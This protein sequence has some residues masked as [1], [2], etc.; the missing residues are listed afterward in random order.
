[1]LK[2][3][4]SLLFIFLF[5]TA[6]LC[7]A[8]NKVAT[9]QWRPA[10]HFTPIKTW[11]NDPNGLF[12]DQG[13]YH[14]YFQNNPFDNV[15]GHMSWGHAVSKDLVHWTHLPVAIP[16]INKKDTTISIFSG[17]AV[18]D[19][20]N[21]SGF[22]IHKKSPIVAIFTGDL[23]K[24]K[25]EA[26]Y[27][28]YSNDTGKTFKLYTDH[29]VIDLNRPDFRDPNVF[30]Y[31]PTKQWIMA[32]SLVHEHKIRFYSSSNLKQW[33]LLSDFG[34][35][36]YI[37][38]D[39]ECPS[40]MPL[41]VDGKASE[42]KWVLL[43]SCWG[44]K[45]PYMQY[46]I[47]DFDG[48]YFKNENPSGQVLT[49]DNGDCFY[50][51]I[52]WRL[53]KNKQILLGWLTPG[54]IDTHPWRGQMS[55][56]RDLSLRT[57]SDGIRLFQAPAS[58]IRNKLKKLSGGKNDFWKN[59]Y[60][61]NQILVPKNLETYHSNAYWIE[62]SFKI[63][64]ATK[65]GFNIMEDSVSGSKIIVGYD[66]GKGVLFVNSK[67]TQEKYKSSGNLFLS[68]PL[69]PIKG[70]IQLQILLDKSSLE[71]F[72]NDG[73]KVI[74]TITYPTKNEKGISLFSEGK[75]VIEKMHIWDLSKVKNR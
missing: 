30:W 53:K 63:S 75:T 23:P 64:G 17:S 19:K 16:E 62:A 25:K 60:V 22:A 36:G 14:L 4:K 72:G 20:N 35:A 5:C 39:W 65:L 45:G 38:H 51:A 3:L 31:K 40:L 28:A 66:V 44:E 27:I 48:Q 42:T 59:L 73:R 74:T 46:F 71:V 54:K 37:G 1:M 24:Q 8:Q 56:P 10:Y 34:P 9:P 29:P 58:I 7:Q 61:N 6:T 67:H 57:T 11:T 33:H 68:T 13:L 2:L 55:I 41:T 49:V 32:V 12:Y 18:M 70:K 50:A 69:K 47:G 21:T 43:V 26:Q 52:P 15:W